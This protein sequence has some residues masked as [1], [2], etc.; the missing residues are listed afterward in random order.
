M[1]SKNIMRPKIPNELEVKLKNVDMAK[2]ELRIANYELE[3]A[4]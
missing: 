3:I 4:S 1:A 2:H